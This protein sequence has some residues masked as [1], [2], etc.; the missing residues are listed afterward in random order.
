[1]LQLQTARRTMFIVAFV[2][3]VA[4]IEAQRLPPLNTI[5]EHTFATAYS[6]KGSYSTSGLSLGQKEDEPDLLFN[7][8]CGSSTSFQASFAGADFGLLSLLGS[9]SEFPI[10]NVTAHAAFNFANV[11]GKGNTF[12]EQVPAEAGS[13]YAIL[14]TESPSGLPGAVRALFAVE[15]SQDSCEDSAQSCSIRYAVLD[16]TLQTKVA[17]SPGFDWTK[18][19]APPLA[20][21]LAAASAVW[22]TAMEGPDVWYLEYVTAD[23]TATCRVLESVHGIRFSAP[24]KDLGGARTAPMGNGGSF[25]VRPPLNKDEVPIVRPYV[26]VKDIEKAVDDAKRA[27]AVV[28]H[29]PLHVPNKG[30]FAI[31]T[32]GG[33]EHG[34]WQL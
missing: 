31:M 32:T 16:Y 17:Q 30:T 3:I 23:V 21:R 34:L 12:Q 9:S 5:L 25:G 4:D 28:I 22:P 27:G 24:D 13:T 10:E 14:R 1:M 8:A 26:L 6:C 15:T 20:P 7:G 11:A 33:T 2:S 19:N 29:P 18:P